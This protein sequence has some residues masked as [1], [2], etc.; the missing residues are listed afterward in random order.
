MAILTVI[1][2]KRL[3][4]PFL[5]LVMLLNT[6]SHPLSPWQQASGDAMLDLH[7]PYAQ[8]SKKYLQMPS[9]FTRQEKTHPTS[10]TQTEWNTHNDLFL[11]FS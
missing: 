11:S 10:L 5:K 3:F 8:L 2:K 9:A 4:Q 1:C 6:S 7:H